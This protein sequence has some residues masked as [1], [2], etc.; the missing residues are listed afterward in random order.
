MT[1]R[2]EELKAALADR[3]EIDRQVGQGGMPSGIVA[4]VGLRYKPASSGCT[5]TS[6]FLDGPLTRLY[7]GNTD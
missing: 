5:T 1:Q 4:A 2:L 6:G 7:F 3:Y